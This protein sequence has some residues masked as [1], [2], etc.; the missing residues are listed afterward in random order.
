MT[1]WTQTIRRENEALK[2]AL[3]AALLALRTIPQSRL[4]KYRNASDSDST[5]AYRKAVQEVD[6]LALAAREE[7]LGTLADKGVTL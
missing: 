6:R 5:L 2:E 4:D 7:I 3:E 1:H